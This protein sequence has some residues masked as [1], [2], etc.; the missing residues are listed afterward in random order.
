VPTL[1]PK[2]K[3]W[4]MLTL[5][6]CIHSPHVDAE[7]LCTSINILSGYKFFV[8]CTDPTSFSLSQEDP[9][10]WTIEGCLRSAQWEVVVIPP[11][12]TL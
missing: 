1:P 2:T 3:Y 11:G 6:G 5:S 8:V 9:T 12:A 10:T 7:G 4:G